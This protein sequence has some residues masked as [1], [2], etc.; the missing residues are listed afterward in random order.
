LEDWEPWLLKSF[1]GY[2]NSA[3]SP[4]GVERPRHCRLGNFYYPTWG[5]SRFAYGHFLATS[6]QVA[7][8]SQLCFLDDDD[9]D[10]DLDALNQVILQ[11]SAPGSTSTVNTPVYMLPPKPISQMFYSLDTTNANSLR[12]AWTSLYVVT[13]VDDRY[14]MWGS[15]GLTNFEQGM[16]W[17][18]LYTAFM[19]V[20]T[21]SQTSQQSSDQ[22][23]ALIDP[24]TKFPDVSWLDMVGKPIP[25]VGDALAANLQCRWVRTMEGLYFL[26]DTTTA[27]GQLSVFFGST[28][29]PY[30]GNPP[31]NVPPAA[32]Q[33]PL[34]W[35]GTPQW[36]SVRAGGMLGTGP[37]GQQNSVNA[38]ADQVQYAT[39]ALLPGQV[40]VNLPI[41]SNG[42]FPAYT[43]NASQDST[44]YVPNQAVTYYGVNCVV[45]YPSGD[46]P[47]DA[48][49]LY[50]PNAGA[51]PV[52]IF[53]TFQANFDSVSGTFVN[54][55]D[56]QALAVRIAT[57]YCLWRMCPFDYLFNGICLP[58]ISGYDW[59]LI[60]SVTDSDCSTRYMSPPLLFTEPSYLQHQEDLGVFVPDEGWATVATTITARSSAGVWGS[61]TATVQTVL[62]QLT[63]PNPP[64]EDPGM[65]F[66]QFYNG[67]TVFTLFNPWNQTVPAGK[68]VYVKTY[69]DIKYLDGADC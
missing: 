41:M 36:G 65:G 42:F 21:L 61:G 54:S 44:T 47:E 11:I 3:F 23:D 46:E 5:L 55:A 58:A 10:P 20:T 45:G 1:P 27:Q 9:D 22:I 40:I 34:V 66:P 15:P 32:P 35:T 6:E 39:A 62:D 17:V 59:L 53:D 69:Q 2:G 29:V 38:I 52:A 48:M 4:Q 37:V 16:D 33:T 28:F 49:N 8:L 64:T 31:P 57:Q 7:A 51:F 12:A 67:T 43:Y 14:F 30:V 63:T 26:T 24:S 18:D 56:M 19:T 68:L 13:F 60:F 25:I 50:F